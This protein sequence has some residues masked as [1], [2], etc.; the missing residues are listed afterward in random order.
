MAPVTRYFS[1]HSDKFRPCWHCSRFE[2]L[3]YGGSAALCTLRNG[4]RVQSMPRDG[5]GMFERDVGADDEPERGPPRENPGD[6][7]REGA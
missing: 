4:P 5:C 3:I 2:A 1:P 7:H 6:T